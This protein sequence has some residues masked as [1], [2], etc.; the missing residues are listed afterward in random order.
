MVMLNDWPE[1]EHHKT[2][3]SDIERLDMETG[4]TESAR[5]GRTFNTGATRDT[6]QDKLDWEGFI[7]PLWMQRFAQYMH[8]HRIQV[9]G[10]LRDADNWQMGMP[11]RQ[12]IRS[13]IRHTWDLWLLYRAGPK[14]DDPVGLWEQRLLELLCAIHFNVQG[15]GYELLIGRDVSED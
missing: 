5:T 1:D 8:T 15:L 11:R 6:D 10:E 3:E 12:Y 2:L 7:S 13:L 9:D 14:D 4:V